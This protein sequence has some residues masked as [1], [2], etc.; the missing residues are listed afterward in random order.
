MES[1]IDNKVKKTKYSS[2]NQ[3]LEIRELQKGNE[4]YFVLLNSSDKNQSI[5]IDR[6]VL[7][8]F[9]D[10]KIENNKINIKPFGCGIVKVN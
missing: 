4:S 9:G 2:I 3:G 5:K 8:S 1:I 10:I 6:N 7:S